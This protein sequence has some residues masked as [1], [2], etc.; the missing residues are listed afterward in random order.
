MSDSERL[1]C[2]FSENDL[3]LVVGA[4]DLKSIERD[5]DSFI[6]NEN[7]FQMI[8]TSPGPK[9]TGAIRFGAGRLKKYN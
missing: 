9:Y 6:R 1:S 3:Q 4:D 8:V 5:I 7:S 2:S